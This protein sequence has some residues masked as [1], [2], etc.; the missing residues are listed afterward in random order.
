MR[1]LD[2]NRLGLREPKARSRTQRGLTV[3]SRQSL[4]FRLFQLSAFPNRQKPSVFPLQPSC[5]T[6][7]TFL[8]LS[9]FANF[10]NGVLGLFKPLKGKI[11]EFNHLKTRAK[12]Y[13][14]VCEQLL[15][16]FL[17]WV[18]RRLF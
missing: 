8:N 15:W 7:K 11:R 3:R 9:F 17:F 2:S 6:E 5:K 18:L 13:K 4:I 16:R 12:V 14:V 1:W 10:N